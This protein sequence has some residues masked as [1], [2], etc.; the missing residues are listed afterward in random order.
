M[1]SPTKEPR[2]VKPLSDIATITVREL[3]P[4][5][6]G[7]LF[8]V[9]SLIQPLVFL[10]LFGPLLLGSVDEAVFGPGG[11]LQ[12]F[13]PG[14]MVMIS[15]VG[16]STMGSN[17]LTEVQ[18]GAHERLLVT[19]LTRGSLIIGRALKEFAPLVVQALVIILV[20]MPFGFSPDP[21]GS[22]LGV[23]LLG[24]LGIGLGAL[25]YALAIAVRHQEWAFWGIQQT[26][27]F[28]VLILSGILLPVDSGPDWLAAVAAFNPLTYVVEA[29]RALFAGEVLTARVGWGALAALLVAALGLYVGVRSVRRSPV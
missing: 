23:L 4:I 15:L 12:W 18:T 13:V 8:L 17:L 29:E 5:L 9:V 2:P 26:L 1:T 14:I 6:R 21:L 24:V 28:P 10:G 25:S 3:R 11:A 20:A 16:T 19:P 27:L 22:V 7:P